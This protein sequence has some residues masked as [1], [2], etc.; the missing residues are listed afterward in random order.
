MR[1]AQIQK[2][3][4][5]FY[6]IAQLSGKA[7]EVVAE[8]SNDDRKSYKKIVA[9]LEDE[10][11]GKKKKGSYGLKFERLKWDRSESASQ[12][13]R[14]LKKFAKIKFNENKDV[15][16]SQCKLQFLRGAPR[17]IENRIRNLEV[18]IGRE[19]T[20]KEIVEKAEGYNQVSITQE[21]RQN[22]S[23]INMMNTSQTNQ[24]NNPRQARRSPFNEICKSC[25]Q[26]GHQK[27][28]CPQGRKV[29]RTGQFVPIAKQNEFP[30]NNNPPN[31]NYTRNNNNNNNNSNNNN[32]NYGNNN[33]RNYQP[34]D[35]RNRNYNANNQNF[36]YP[37]SNYNSNIRN[38]N[39]Y[40]Q[41]RNNNYNNQN[42]N[43]NNYNN[44]KNYNQNSNN[45]NRN[46][47]FSNN[48]RRNDD[49][50]GNGGYNTSNNY[51]R[52]NSNNG[53]RNFN[54]NKNNSFTQNR[55]YNNRPPTPRPQQQ[56][57]YYRSQSDNY[58]NNQNR[59]RN[60][61]NRPYNPNWRNQNQQSR[62]GNTF[63][64][65][66]HLHNTSEPNE[67]VLQQSITQSPRRASTPTSNQNFQ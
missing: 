50:N 15:I 12:F 17:E 55:N 37:N 34:D 48:Y 44:N 33:Q 1:I 14:Q 61:R 35:N 52:N 32:S 28:D 62:Y 49:R 66:E 30:R 46:D 7:E 2:E 18:E 40:Q 64:E 47:Q 53:N 36:R 59:N 27:R 58:N 51:Q 11:S 19:L 65:N 5:P 43:N 20:C 67:D 9:A 3:D 26:N 41:Q 8:L 22:R 63:R 16:E 60:Y 24:S 38:N 57:P 13:M 4:K 31:N 45:H 54:N 10:F 29:V 39:N 21:N 56:R 6:L 23:H 25:G 42:N